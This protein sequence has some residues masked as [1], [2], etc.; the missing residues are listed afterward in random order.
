VHR[1]LR[2]GLLESPVIPHT[3]TRAVMATL[4]AVR[5]QIGVGYLS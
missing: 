3:E 1:C 4:D 2:E 5:E